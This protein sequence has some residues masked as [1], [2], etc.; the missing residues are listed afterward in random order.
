[1]AHKQMFPNQRSLN[2]AAKYNMI[3]NS[4]M[5]YEQP[6]KNAF[7]H[8]KQSNYG[9][10]SDDYRYQNMIATKVDYAGNYQH[11]MYKVVNGTVIGAQNIIQLP[12]DLKNAHNMQV[13]K[14]SIYLYSSS[15]LQIR[16]LS[17]SAIKNLNNRTEN[18]QSGLK[19]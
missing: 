2:A 9:M 4:R 15:L 6:M 13:R 8:S 10:N 14:D 18:L 7:G 1:M 17:R 12:I 5:M 16:R 3:H 11:E 19:S